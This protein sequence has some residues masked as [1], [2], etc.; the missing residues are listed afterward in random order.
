MNA[1]KK[2]VLKSGYYSAI[3]PQANLV[4]KN[5]PIEHFEIAVPSLDEI[6]IRVVTEGAPKA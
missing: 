4:K 2:L 6:F 3:S 1:H 5:V